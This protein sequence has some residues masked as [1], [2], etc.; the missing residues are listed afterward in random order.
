VKFAPDQEEIDKA[1]E[2]A[3]AALSVQLWNERV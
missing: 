1:L 2:R 3:A